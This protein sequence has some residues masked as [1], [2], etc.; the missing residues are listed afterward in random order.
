MRGLYQLRRPVSEDI[1][2]ACMQ[3]LEALLRLRA[4]AGERAAA[5]WWGPKTAWRLQEALT[6]VVY[7]SDE[8]AVAAEAERV[9]CALRNSSLVP[10]QAAL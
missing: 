6:F 3:A 7:M 2:L 5:R 1:L 8:P 9:L 10:G 4:A